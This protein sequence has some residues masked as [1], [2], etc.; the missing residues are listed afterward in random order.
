MSPALQAVSCIKG[1]FVTVE[2]PGK[3]RVT[4]DSTRCGAWPYMMSRLLSVSLISTPDSPKARN[5]EV[6][7]QNQEVLFLP[8]VQQLV[9]RV[10][11]EPSSA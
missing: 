4:K 10:G 5:W 3:P 6:V 7:P 8:R 11:W 2:P 9:T 1:G